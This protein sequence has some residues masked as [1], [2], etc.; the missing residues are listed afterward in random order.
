[1]R[2]LYGFLLY[3]YG[4]FS[5]LFFNMAVRSMFMGSHKSAS[6]LCVTEHSK[7]WSIKSNL[8]EKIPYQ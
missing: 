8:A 5:F 6:R 1:M 3:V 2:W 7:K 4:C